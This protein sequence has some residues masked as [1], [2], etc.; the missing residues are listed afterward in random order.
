MSPRVSVVLPIYNYARYLDQRIQSLLAQDF[1]DFEI[2]AVDDGSTDGSLAVVE[3]YAR[4]PRIR[5]V[6][7]DTNGGLPYLRW[8]EGAALAKGEYLLFAGADDY[9]VATLLRRLVALMDAHP[10]MGIAHA[11]SWMIDPDG[12]RMAL[13]PRGARYASDFIAD[14]ADEA[15]YLFRVNT[16]PNASAVLLRRSVF[17]ACGA[18]D[19][20]MRLCA[21]WMLWARMLTM[22][23]V[24]YIAT[25]LNSFRTHR[26]TLRALE[27]PKWLIPEQYEVMGFMTQA[28]N[29]PAD[30]REPAFDRIARE[31]L[32]RLRQVRTAE[33]LSHEWRTWRVGR[34]VDPA[35]SRRMSRLL[36]ER[37]TR[38]LRPRARAG[39]AATPE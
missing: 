31:F 20:S 25:A 17:E 16:V 37:L 18:F 32:P 26:R 5:T 28:F 6:R 21:D 10:K 3:K 4:D 38:G 11:R 36:I 23:E 27:G 7:H 35:F 29:L 2:I 8:N 1:S 30:V 34:A 24:G 13:L 33:Q 22:S 9:C 12:N 14:A 39:S 15:A 19:T